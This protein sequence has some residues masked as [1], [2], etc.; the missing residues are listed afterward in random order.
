MLRMSPVLV[1][2][3][4]N[5]GF[6]AEH[7]ARELRH[8]RSEKVNFWYDHNAERFG[9]LTTQ[10]PPLQTLPR[11][12]NTHSAE[13]RSMQDVKLGAMTLV[14]V[15]LREQRIC[16]LPESRFVSLNAFEERKKLKAQLN[17]YR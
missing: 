6:E 10:V 2:V 12:R 4:R 16:M 11:N 5:L 1:I 3:E 8:L 7:M 14:N 15:M 13:R 17:I 9:V